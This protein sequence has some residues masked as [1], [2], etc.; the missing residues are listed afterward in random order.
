MADHGIS[1]FIVS[2]ASSE[3]STSIGVRSQD[4]PLS[5][6]VLEKEFF[7]EISMGSINEIQVEYNLATIAIVGQNMKHVPGIA[8]KFFGEHHHR[9]DGGEDARGEDDEMVVR[10]G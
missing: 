2:Q 4:A 5:K 8:S 6:E 10:H 7:H 1:V 9:A 3:N